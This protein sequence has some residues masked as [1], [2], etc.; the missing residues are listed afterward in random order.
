MTKLTINVGAQQNDG[1]GDPIRLA[2]TK[3]NSNFSEVYT[4]LDGKAVF[5]SQVNRAGKYLKTDGGTTSFENID[6]NELT[7]KPSIPAAQVNSDW[8]SSTGVSA[9]LNKPQLAGVA[10][11]GNYNDLTNKP[12]L[13]SVATS[14]SYLDLLYLPALFSGNYNDLTNKPTIFSGS[15]ADLT[16]KPIVSAPANNYGANGDKAGMIAFDSNYIYYC[17][18]DYVDDNTSIWK[19]VELVAW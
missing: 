19:R 16:N 13:A 8:N 18:A 3:I 10:T 9:I 2:F 1:T 4:A 11:S 5:P 17:T 15:Y 6:Y 12:N 14:G 7:N